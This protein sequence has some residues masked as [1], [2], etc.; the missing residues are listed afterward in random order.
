M[1]AIGIGNSNN[2]GGCAGDTNKGKS[3]PTRS[4]LALKGSSKIVS[5]FFDYSIN[6]ILYQRGIYP[7]D[8]FKMVKKYGLYMLIST[9]EEVKAYI[10][11]ILS[12]LNKW[13]YNGKINKLI[14]AIIDKTND[15]PVERW[16]FDV[17]I[18]NNK[19][20][21]Q[22]MDE[23]MPDKEHVNNTNKS[24]EEIQQEIQAIIRQITASI[25]FLP[26]LEGPHTFNVLVYANSN[27]KNIPS[28]WI[29]SD[30][31]E[32]KNGGETVGF[33]SFSTSNHK[34]DTFVTYKINNLID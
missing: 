13:I 34:V 9:D 3:P 18:F 17:E 5:D 32:I 1:K 30:D 31:K 6:S 11:R 7:P 4:K 21:D 24:K 29:D 15:E 33:R 26:V 19:N 16:E 8:D 28:E 27:T 25:T 22:E 14:V 23:P 12:Q 20:L 2:N 10:R